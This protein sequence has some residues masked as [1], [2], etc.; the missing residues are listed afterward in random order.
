MH[1]TL[2]AET[3]RD[4]F[5]VAPTGPPSIL[6]LPTN[7]WVLKHFPIKTGNVREP[8]LLHEWTL[9]EQM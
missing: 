2:T 8:R 6:Q 3:L 1:S 7:Q 4:G 5:G 9:K